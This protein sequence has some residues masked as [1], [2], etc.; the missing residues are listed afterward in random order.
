MTHSEIVSSIHAHADELAEALKRGHDVELR[1]NPKVHGVKAYELRK[2]PLIGGEAVQ[3][4]SR[5]FDALGNTEH[6]EAEKTA[7]KADITC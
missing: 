5:R 6:V 2:C 4:D 7:V 3:G 1:L